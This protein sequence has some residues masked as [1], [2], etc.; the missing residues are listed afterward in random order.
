MKQKTDSIVKVES[1]FF[2]FE[3][4]PQFYWG[5]FKQAQRKPPLCKG[6]WHVKRDGGVVNE[7]K[8]IPHRLQRSSLCTREP[9]EVTRLRVAVRV[10]R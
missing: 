3:I 1:V 9:I 8:T 2:V 5:S 10:M 7:R 4:T 6:R